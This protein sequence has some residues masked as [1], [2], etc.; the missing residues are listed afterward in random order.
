MK[1]NNNFD[2]RSTDK[3]GLKCPFASHVRRSNPKDALDTDR[4]TSISVANKHR[5]L[6]RGRSYGK[7]L[8]ENLKPVDCLKAVDD[9]E[10][11]GLHFICINADIAHEFEFIQNAWINN[12]KFNGLYDERDPLVG[13]HTPSTG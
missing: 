12:P 10:K 9:G 11:R 7:P 6:R 1:N 4:K 5:M 2:F 13:S 8:T 3:D